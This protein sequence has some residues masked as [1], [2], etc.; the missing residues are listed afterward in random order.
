MEAMQ[1]QTTTEPRKAQE[2][3]LHDDT[4]QMLFAI[5]LKV[6]YCLAVLDDAPEQTRSG[7][8]HVIADVNDL[9]S[10]LRDRI[11]VLK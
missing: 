9:I 8:N 2:L 11:Y 7:L 6:E 1:A 5:S 10:G 3:R 4:I